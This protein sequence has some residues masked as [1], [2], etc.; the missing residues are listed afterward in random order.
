MADLIALFTTLTVF[1]VG[2]TI[3]DFLGI[4]DHIGHNDDSGG[5]G[6]GDSHDHDHSHSLSDE[7]HG[8]NLIT[9]K[10]SEDVKTEQ[11]I[12]KP[13]FKIISSIMT[14]LRSAVYFSLGFGPT[15]LFAAFTGQSRM[16]GLLWAF[17]VGAA[18]LIGARLVRRLIR[19]DTDS[20]I[21][22]DELLQE[23]G[24][25]LLP[26]EGELISKAAVRQYGR[27]IEVYVRCRDK[28]IKLLKG[29][30]III[31]EYDNDVYWVIPVESEGV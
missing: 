8:S 13:V 23:R 21:K 12:E 22:P 20:S 28:N 29:K 6:H 9:D 4:M 14:V 25:L 7:Q 19:R 11:K 15:G 3:V 2:V 31:E 18:T 5:D 30:E 16:S 1:G 24:V 27:E 17:G 10:N 26:L